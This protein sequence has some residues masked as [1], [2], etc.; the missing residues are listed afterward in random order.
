LDRI[1]I[2]QVLTGPEAYNFLTPTGYPSLPLSGICGRHAQSR[3]L[4]AENGARTPSGLLQI[5][6]QTTGFKNLLKL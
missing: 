5:S 3:S 6:Y 4:S 2:V 1:L